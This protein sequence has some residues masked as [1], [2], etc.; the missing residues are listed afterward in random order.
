M[1]LIPTDV[2]FLALLKRRIYKNIYSEDVRE[3]SFVILKVYH[4]AQGK[5]ANGKGNITSVLC[6]NTNP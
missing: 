2:L 3:G 6:A 1:M 4:L 5:K